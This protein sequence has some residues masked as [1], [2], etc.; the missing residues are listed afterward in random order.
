MDT[1][2]NLL[3]SYGSDGVELAVLLALPVH[4]MYTVNPSRDPFLF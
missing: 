4:R 1:E 2:Y 3:T